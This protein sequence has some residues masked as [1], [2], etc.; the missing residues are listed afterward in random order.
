LIA[1]FV[2]IVEVS[3]TVLEAREESFVQ[4]TYKTAY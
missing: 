1:S 4:Q 3:L 2:E